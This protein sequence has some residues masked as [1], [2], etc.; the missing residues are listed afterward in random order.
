[1]GTDSSKLSYSL[2]YFDKIIILKFINYR[3]V[4]QKYELQWGDYQMGKYYN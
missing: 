3:T 4:N 1:M 2:K